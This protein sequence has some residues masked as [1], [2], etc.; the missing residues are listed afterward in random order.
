MLIT[1]KAKTQGGR[2]NGEV[3]FA[4]GDTKE[5]PDA[6][7]KKLLA[8]FPDRFFEAKS[9]RS[10]EPEK[11]TTKARRPKRNKLYKADKDK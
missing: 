11:E 2:H 1:F 4:D 7:A 5:V 3:S 8:D 9:A 6:I 10:D